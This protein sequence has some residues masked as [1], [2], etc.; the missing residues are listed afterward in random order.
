[1]KRLVLA[2]MI[3]LL[4][5]GIACKDKRPTI[6]EV[7]Y[8][9]SVVAEP[10]TQ[11]EI[12]ANTYG[13]WIYFNSDK[14]VDDVATYYEDFTDKGWSLDYTGSIM[15]LLELNLS[16]GGVGLDVKIIPQGATASQIELRLKEM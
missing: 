7:T 6:K 15:G 4:A 11:A 14:T 1:M 13:K 8:P 3:G 16:K 12:D 9:G 5:L 10:S 2:V